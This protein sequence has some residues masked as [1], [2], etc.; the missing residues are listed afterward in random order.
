MGTLIS[1]LFDEY[2]VIGELIETDT[3]QYAIRDRLFTCNLEIKRFGKVIGHEKVYNRT[4]GNYSPS[5]NRWFDVKG[6]SLPDNSK[7][8]EAIRMMKINKDKNEAHQSRL[9]DIRSF[10]K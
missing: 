4:I 7:Q 3:E 6:K 10:G 2:E 1:L 8:V 5:N 9:D